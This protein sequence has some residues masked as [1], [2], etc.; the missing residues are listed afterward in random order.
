MQRSMACETILY[1]V[2]DDKLREQTRQLALEL[3]ERGAFALAS[4]QAAFNARHGEVSGL[5]RVAHDLLLHTCLDS[6]ESHELGEPFGAKRK[7]DPSKFG[8]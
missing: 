7:P 6:D 8:R 3:A 2:P 4:I 1:L 5:A